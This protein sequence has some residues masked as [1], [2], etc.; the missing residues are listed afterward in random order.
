MSWI[1]S[2]IYSYVVGSRGGD[3]DDDED[4]SAKESEI[5]EAKAAVI[6]EIASHLKHSDDFERV[7]PR[8]V[9]WVYAIVDDNEWN[10]YNTKFV[11][12]ANGKTR[13]FVDLPLNHYT[14]TAFE[15]NFAV[16]E[17]EKS[18]VTGKWNLRIGALP[19][20]R[21]ESR[22]QVISTSVI[23]SERYSVIALMLD[24]RTMRRLTE[25]LRDCNEVDRICTNPIYT[26]EYKRTKEVRLH[27]NV[28]INVPTSC[29]TKLPRLE[30]P[31]LCESDR[32]SVVPPKLD[33]ICGKLIVS[34]KKLDWSKA[35]RAK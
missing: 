22:G 26:L 12:L 28:P 21:Q 14:T 15:R 24:E 4:S 9:E 2:S 29:W 35:Q 23:I 34:A 16:G 25:E 5:R 32:F 31:T 30:M 6:K 11:G 17:V 20:Q 10:E 3:D 18:R 27:L 33:D 8:E 19:E 1:L 13:L 7:E